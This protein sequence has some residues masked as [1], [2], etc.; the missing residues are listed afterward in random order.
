MTRRDFLKKAALA[1][2]VGAAFPKLLPKKEVVPVEAV[3]KAAKLAI[4]WDARNFDG[5]VYYND[6][7]IRIPRS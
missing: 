3:E 6:Q 5:W 4:V 2:A 7:W 1:T